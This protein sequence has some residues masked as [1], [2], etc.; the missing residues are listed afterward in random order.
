VR[1]HTPPQRPSGASSTAFRNTIALGAMLLSIGLGACSGASNDAPVHVAGSP[2]AA[3]TVDHWLSVIQGASGA[4]VADS[5][6]KSVL[7]FLIFSRWILGEAAAEGVHV[8]DDEAQARLELLGTGGEEIPEDTGL[9]GEH[10]LRTLLANARHRADKLWLL[11]LAVL[12]KRLEARTLSRLERQV[13]PAQIAAYYRAHP[14]HYVVPEKRD[15][16]FIV[17]YSDA[18]LAKAVAEI[19]AGKNF[20]SVAKRVSK[21]EPTIKGLERHPQAEKLLAKHVFEARP[22]VMMGPYKQSANRYEFEVTRIILSR[23]QTLAEA[24]AAIRKR[25]AM[26]SARAAFVSTLERRWGTKTSCRDGGGVAG[27]TGAAAS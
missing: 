21:D 17:T 6:R 24:E 1:R 11:K 25:L 12:T 22:H 9:P 3:A 18:S 27:C 15:I 20:I 7:S 5:Q 23:R 19:R 8:T 13:T 10:L 4:A 26:A 2:I 16:E 14:S